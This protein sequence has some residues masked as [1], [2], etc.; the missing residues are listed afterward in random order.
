MQAICQHVKSTHIE[1]VRSVKLEFLGIRNVEIVNSHD[2]YHHHIDKVYHQDTTYYE[3]I[4]KLHESFQCDHFVIASVRNRVIRWICCP[5]LPALQDLPEHTVGDILHK[6]PKCCQLQRHEADEQEQNTHVVQP[7]PPTTKKHISAGRSH[8][9]SGLF[10][11]ANFAS[12]GS[13]GSVTC[14]VTCQV[15]QTRAIA[16][17]HM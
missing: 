4:K 6:G 1:T 16:Y 5:E 8:S 12:I 14:R 13:S 10:S 2:K 7:M 15:A 17:I 9:Q 11:N 3:E